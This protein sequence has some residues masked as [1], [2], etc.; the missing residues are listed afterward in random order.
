M[1]ITKKLFEYFL[2]YILPAIFS[3]IFTEWIRRI[4]NY[5]DLIYKCPAGDS[6]CISILWGIIFT[7]GYV[8]LA[9]II[10]AIWD[11]IKHF[12]PKLSKSS[13]SL[14]GVMSIFSIFKNK[15]NLRV[16]V[17]NEGYEIFIVVKNRRWFTD[18]QK[19]RFTFDF[20][21]ED[22]VLK[23]YVFDWIEGS[24]KSGEV[25]IGKRKSK[26][27]HFATIRQLQKEYD[28]HFL[29]GDLLTPFKNDRVIHIRAE[30]LTSSGAKKYLKTD[31]NGNLVLLETIH[32]GMLKFEK[33]NYF[34]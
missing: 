30:G 32:K 29:E 22:R 16:N 5:L 17:K 3:I 12:S 27:L 9:F 11:G 19:V 4:V 8:V 18:I 34:E 13:K 2:F 26:T 25:F 15:N 28:M 21:D 24:N 14:F 1:S 33:Q 23:H 31:L 6:V 10:G 20:L 7:F